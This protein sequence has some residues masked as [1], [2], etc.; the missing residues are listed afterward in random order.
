MKFFTLVFLM[1]LLA[2]AASSA[3]IEITKVPA[4]VD[5][6]LKAYADDN[7]KKTIEFSNFEILS[8]EKFDDFVV[9]HFKA[10][11]KEQRWINNLR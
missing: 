5:Q 8:I 7:L 11:G 10:D 9:I 6:K 2:V 4:N 3:A 1:L